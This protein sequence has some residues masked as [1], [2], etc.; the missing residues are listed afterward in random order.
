MS[1]KPEI[2]AD[3]LNKIKNGRSSELHWF[4]EDTSVS[5][6]ATALLGMANSSGGVV[7]LGLAPRSGKVQ[8]VSNP[9]AAVDKVF[10]AALLV[11]PPLVLPVPHFCEFDHRQVLWITVP[12]GLPHVYSM[13]GRY[14]ERKGAR[15]VSLSDRALRKL[16]VER[17]VLQ[18]EAQVPPGAN[19]DDLDTQK[20]NGYIQTLDLPGDGNPEDIL[21][22]RGCLIQSSDSVEGNSPP[23]YCPTYAALLMF[24]KHPQRWL[25]GAT[26]LAARFSGA[27][28]ADRFIKQDISGTLPEQLSQ[29]LAFV[30]AN[31]RSVVRLVGLKREETS[32]YPLEAVRELLVNAVAHRDYNVQGDNIHLNIYADRIEVHSPGRLPGPV[33]LE[34]LLQARFSR[35]AVIV[36]ILSDLG[37]VERL[38]YG[39]DR[40]VTSMRMY[41]LK[42]PQFEEVAGSFRVGLYRNAGDGLRSPLPVLRDFQDLA[43][44][45]RQELALAFLLRNR[46]ITNSQYQELCPDVSSETLRRDLVEMT[47]QNLLI[48]IGDKR[49]TYYVL[50]K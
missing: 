9:E 24:G 39:L 35:N 7:L 18:F 27:T 25:P 49:A 14:L 50:K 37:Y 44:N 5:Q 26:I 31:L 41:G 45:P 16:L 21:L 33:N 34:N 32:E 28:M 12:R 36:Q 23:E 3:L 38:G 30:Q 15:T 17:G 29:A 2:C 22:W 10:Q 1:N 4:P 46:R 42:A 40:V 6:L 20:V 13:N 19:M 48:K 11:E 8:G 43:L 47:A